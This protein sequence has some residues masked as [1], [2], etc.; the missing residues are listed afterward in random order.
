[1]KEHIRK[2]VVARVRKEGFIA[3]SFASEEESV[4][5]L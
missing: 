2:E 5:W 4:G 3:R 1:M